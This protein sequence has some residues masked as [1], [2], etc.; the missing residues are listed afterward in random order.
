MDVAERFKKIEQTLLARFEEAADVKHKGDR[1]EN[2]EEF[3]RDFLA[4][5]LPR[6]YGVT[7]GE[8]VTRAGGHSHSADIIV[9]DAHGGP[10]LYAGDTAILPIEAVY[11]IIEVKPRLSKAEFVDASKKVESFKRLAPRDLSVIQTREYVTVHRPSRPFGAVFAFD[12]ADNSLESLLANWEERNGEV[13]DVNFFENVVV[14]LGAGL[15]TFEKVDLAAGEK[16]VLL[17]TDEFVDYM[18]TEQK[19]QRNSEEPTGQLVRLVI[20]KRGGESF[21]RFFVYLLIMLE[22]MSLGVADLGRYLDPDIPIAI[23]R[24]S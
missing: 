24:E 8:V 6:R 10:V 14:V 7:K 13:H 12:L 22:R 4:R 1:G 11:G 3:V 16:H 19:R 20:D 5:H 9:Y 21:G 18:L 2:R 17:D 23:R 15:L